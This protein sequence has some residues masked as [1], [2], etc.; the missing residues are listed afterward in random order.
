MGRNPFRTRR[1]GLSGPQPTHTSL[2]K[3]PGSKWGT[4][5]AKPGQRIAREGVFPDSDAEGARTL[6]QA[7]PEAGSDLDDREPQLP[8]PK[9]RRSAKSTT[10]KEVRAYA[11]EARQSSLG[12][13]SAASSPPLRFNSAATL[14]AATDLRLYASSHESDTPGPDSDD[15][16]RPAL[17]RKRAARARMRG[18]NFEASPGRSKEGLPVDQKGKG[19]YRYADDKAGARG[20]DEQEQLRRARLAALEKRLG[21][22]VAEGGRGAGGREGG[23]DKSIGTS[24]TLIL[25]D[26]SDSNQ[27]EPTPAFVMASTSRVAVLPPGELRNT[28]QQRHMT[29]TALRTS[30]T[31]KRRNKSAGTDDLFSGLGKTLRDGDE[32][33][34][35]AVVKGVQE[36][37]RKVREAKKRAAAAV[38]P[39]KSAQ[40]GE[41]KEL[42]AGGLFLRESEDEHGDGDTDSEEDDGRGGG[43]HK[44]GNVASRTGLAPRR[45][46]RRKVREATIDN[47]DECADPVGDKDDLPESAQSAYAHLHL[48]RFVDPRADLARRKR[49]AS[50]DSPPTSDFSSPSSDE[51]S[52]RD[53][54][55][56]EGGQKAREARE[57]NE[58]RK[59]EREM[60]RKKAKFREERRPG[61]SNPRRN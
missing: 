12:A 60:K 52:T 9:R 30:K 41:G 56:K 42:H 21:T 6:G 51:D 16:D 38:G 29:L 20:D 44:E 17:S 48:P 53:E 55:T 1:G 8:Q 49:L 45:R 32:G 2:G 37:V 22:D 27:N 57:L 31:K 59:V 26:S 54:A 10:E 47:A 61:Y 50:L 11:A 19:V 46:R 15:P 5:R 3:A 13:V 34:A 25:S 33:R 23:A 14:D 35:S 40:G 36:H 4:K 58:M 39:G 18:P 7:D 24:T 28:S 43:G